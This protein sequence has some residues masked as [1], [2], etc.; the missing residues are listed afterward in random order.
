MSNHQSESSVSSVYTKEFGENQAITAKNAKEIFFLDAADLSRLP[1]ERQKGWGAYASGTGACKYF[2]A[3]DV[4][5]S[6]LKIFGSVEEL[7]RKA[8][9]QEETEK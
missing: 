6:A 3:N 4:R 5:N 2:N 7:M 9:G 8:D 1:F